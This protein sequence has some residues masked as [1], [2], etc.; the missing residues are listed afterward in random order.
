MLLGGGAAFVVIHAA[1]V[2][3]TP[4]PTSA[5]AT[6]DGWWL[7]A[8]ETVIAVAAGMMVA[9]WFALRRHSSRLLAR[10]VSWTLGAMAGMAIVLAVVGPGNLWPIV[11]VVGWALLGVSVSVAGGLVAATR[12]SDGPRVQ[13]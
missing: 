7:D 3:V 13:E 4:L 1:A 11:L 9:S 8:M 10:A 5:I 2:R 6:F 12:R